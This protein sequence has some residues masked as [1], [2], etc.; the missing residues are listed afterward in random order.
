[1]LLDVIERGPENGNGS[2]PPV[3]FLHGL[4]GRARNFGFFQRRLATTRRV[5]ALDLRNHGG[6]PHGPMD[7]PTMAADVHETLAAHDA[8]PATI[9]GHSMG[10]KVAM[11]LA[12]QT[13]ACVHALLVADIAPGPGGHAHSG[14]IATALAGL[15]FPATLTLGEADAWLAPAIAEKPVRD[16]MKQNI[17]LGANPHWQIGLEQIVAGM[18]QV[19]GWPALPPGTQ[20]GGSVLFVAGGASP[21]V[22]P[23]HYPLMRQLFPHYRLVR[24]KGAGHW[25][26]AEQPWEFLR[27]VE[28]FLHATG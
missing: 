24:L 16:M 14:A 2:L 26:H 25:L 1:M 9:I 22:Q 4:F 21:Y 11:M 28:E 6:S 27:V 12:L 8:L 19:V 13:P 5:L 7:Y 3:V 18:A 10:G 20:Y 23:D 17:V 15:H